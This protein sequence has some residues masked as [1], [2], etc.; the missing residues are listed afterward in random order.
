M[1]K[2]RILPLL[3]LLMT[4]SVAA[5]GQNNWAVIGPFVPSG[6]EVL[7]VDSALTNGDTLFDYLVVLKKQTERENDLRP[8]LFITSNSD[9]TYALDLRSDSTIYAHLDGPYPGDDNFSGIKLYPDSIL[10]YYYAGMSTRWSET[11][12]FV[13]DPREKTWMLS[14][15]ESTTDNIYDDFPP[16]VTIERFEGK[17]RVP[18]ARF[19]V[20]KY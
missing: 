10:V 13:F 9:N 15:I 7:A 3:P 6:Y 11:Y 5:Q 1:P 2:R 16:D 8:L 20:M 4:I 19:S 18:I 12:K 14:S 17:D